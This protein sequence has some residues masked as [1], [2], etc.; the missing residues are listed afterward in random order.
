MSDK[1]SR[2]IEAGDIISVGGGKTEYAVWVARDG[3]DALW[4]SS[5][6]VSRPRRV[7]RAEARYLR[8]D[9]DLQKRLNPRT[10]PTD[11]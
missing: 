1:E 7:L 9:S 5:L 8:T 11:S 2:T 3:E 10:L 6:T 4:A